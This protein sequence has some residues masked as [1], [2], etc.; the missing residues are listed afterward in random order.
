MAKLVLNKDGRDPDFD[1]EKPTF[2][3]EIDSFISKINPKHSRCK[4]KFYSCKKNPSQKQL[5]QRIL[6]EKV[7]CRALMPKNWRRRSPSVKS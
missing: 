2:N 4:L 7:N 5:N 1:S 6:A 3:F